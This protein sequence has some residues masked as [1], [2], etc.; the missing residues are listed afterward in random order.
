PP[1]CVENHGAEGI[2]E[3]VLKEPAL[4]DSL[5]IIDTT[6]IGLPTIQFVEEC[7]G[8]LSMSAGTGQKNVVNRKSIINGM[9]CFPRYPSVAGIQG[10]ASGFFARS[11]IQLFILITIMFG[12]KTI[13]RIPC[14]PKS[15]LCDAC[16]S[17]ILFCSTPGRFAPLL[18]SDEFVCV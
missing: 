7:H 3:D 18:L 13:Q 9:R 1:S 6:T 14:A 2:A 12:R 11:L 4:R 16:E 8:I 5:V 15:S 17:H 10:R